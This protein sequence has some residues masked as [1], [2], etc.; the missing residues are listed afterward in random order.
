MVYA[1]FSIGIL[2]FIVWS[3]LLASLLSDMEILNNFAI[4]WNSLV[5]FSTLNGKNLH[6]YTQSAGNLSLNSFNAI[7]QSASETTR[8]TSFNFVAFRIYYNTL[9]N[10]D[11]KHLSDNWLSWFIGFVEGDG[12]IQTY[13]NRTKLRLVI[14]QKES[15][16]LYHIHNSLEIG[17]VKHYPQGLKLNKSGNGNKNDFYR[18]TVDKLSHI[19]L[20]ALLFNGNLAMTHRI[21]QLSLWITVLNLKFKTISIHSKPV[22]ITLEDAWLSGFTDAEGCF[23]VS[24]TLNSRYKLGSVIKMRYLLDQTDNIIL[25][26]IKDLFGFGKVTLRSQTENV[27]RYTTTG[28]NSMSNVLTYF[29]LFPLKSQKKNSLDKWANIHNMVMSKVHLTEEGSNE[30]KILSKQ[31]N[32]NNSKTNKTGLAKP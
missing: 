11:S 32:I 26:K 18:F 28:F 1:I 6:S 13:A 19:L 2:G 10:K 9:L 17:K 20:L 7:K 16:I 3:W 5:L 27:Y 21:N 12:A 25:V 29:K 31:I 23:N 30:I 24:V 15:A 22:K 4:C 8:E 14:T